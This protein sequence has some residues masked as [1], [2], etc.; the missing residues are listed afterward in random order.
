MVHTIG[1]RSFVFLTGFSVL[2]FLICLD[3]FMKSK[4]LLSILALGTV[5]SAQQAMANTGTIAFKGKIV[6]STCQ[7]TTDTANQTVQLGTWPTSALSTAGQTTSPQTFQIDLEQCDA[8]NYTVRLD[9]TTVSATGDNANLL[10]VTGGATNVGI[11][12]TGLDNKIVP[13][14]TA[15]ANGYEFAIPSGSTTAT[16][17]LKAFYKATGA[18]T[19]GD[20]NATANFSIE[21]K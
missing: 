19:A 11:Q 10:A 14:N 5:V 21:Y 17:D 2:F 9:G 7:A 3:S 18:A 12:V 8:G 15:L 16:L 6:T 1:W 4:V 20:A 13:I